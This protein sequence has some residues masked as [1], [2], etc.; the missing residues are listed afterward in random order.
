MV[1]MDWLVLIMVAL[2]A[3]QLGWTCRAG[4]DAK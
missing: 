2:A 4:F 1:L 3:F